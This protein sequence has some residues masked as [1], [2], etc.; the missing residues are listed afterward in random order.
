MVAEVQLIEPLAHFFAQRIF[1][2]QLEMFQSTGDPDIDEAWRAGVQSRFAA[3]V[4]EQRKKKQILDEIL[5][6]EQQAAAR[7]TSSC[8]TRFP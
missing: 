3:V 8:S 4:A 5:R 6:D 2:A 7:R 1:G